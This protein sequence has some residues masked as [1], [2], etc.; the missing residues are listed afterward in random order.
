MP[1]F[2][3]KA[4]PKVDVIDRDEEITVRAELPG[5]E[6]EN[7]KVTLSGNV[8]TIKGE[9]KRQTEEE[10]GEF[11]RSEIYRGSYQRT[12]TL[13]S[14]VDESRTKASMKDGILEVVM[15]KVGPTKRHSVKVE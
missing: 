13:P 10:K 15:P 11:R 4:M 2:D 14:A 6:K 7:V 3:F 1:G 8:I 12:V 5:V 9:S